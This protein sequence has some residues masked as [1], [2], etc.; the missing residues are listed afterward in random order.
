M[1]HVALRM[2]SPVA[3]FSLEMSKE[4][5]AMRLLCAEAQVDASRLRGGF[6]NDGEWRRL[7]EAAGK[8]ASAPIYID[9]TASLPIMKMQAIARRL[10]TEKDI[11][12]IMVD[13]LQLMRADTTN[14]NA[15]RE[16]IVSE[17]S[18]NLKAIAKELRVPVIALSQLNRGLESRTDKRPM[19]SDLRECVVGQTPVMLADGR[20]VSVEALVGTRPQV[21]A[22]DAEARQVV[23]ARAEEVVS[24]GVQPVWALT[25]EGAR[26]LTATATHRVLTEQGWVEVDQ[27]TTAHRVA[28][29]APPAASLEGAGA[30]AEAGAPA[31]L[32]WA[33]VLGVEA[34]G[35]QAVF[36]LSVPGPA[37]WLSQGVVSHN[38]GSIEQ[39]ADVIMFI[40]RD[41]VYNKDSEEK[42]VAE[43]IISK[44]RNGPLGTARL[45][46]MSSFTRFENLARDDAPDF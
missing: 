21:W 42:G 13:Y 22:W 5:L 18:R 10:K 8:L 6:L 4:Q 19:N 39:D 30:S 3:Y 45:K 33:A 32:T 27:L 12:M 40:Y 46:W 28:V 9:D 41:E 44:Q 17:I 43:V 7:I 29:A 16:Q 15:S 31:A 38:S 20:S 2:Q 34:A 25:L 24:V 26:H 36:D 37:S 14:K 11:G 23:A 1:A 35:A